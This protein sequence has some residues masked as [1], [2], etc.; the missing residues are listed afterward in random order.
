MFDTQCT[1]L[2]QVD[3][4]IRISYIRRFFVHEVWSTRL[5]SHSAMGAR[6]TNSEI[7]RLITVDAEGVDSQTVVFH[8][9][10]SHV[11]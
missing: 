4:H 5:K 3:L 10:D 2:N 1:T 6:R 9:V 11:S 8:I 7:G